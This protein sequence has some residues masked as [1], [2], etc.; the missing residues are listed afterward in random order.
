MGVALCNLVP[1][2]KVPV[3][4]TTFF[5]GQAQLW[6]EYWQRG[7]S[8]TSSPLFC[9]VLAGLRGLEHFSVNVMKK[10]FF[11][12]SINQPYFVSFCSVCDNTRVHLATVVEN[13]SLYI[14]KKNQRLKQFTYYDVPS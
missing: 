8:F 9:A 12:L 11:N 6:Q 10:R 2:G 7:R 1:E 13:I 5:C 4:E 14:V 3:Q